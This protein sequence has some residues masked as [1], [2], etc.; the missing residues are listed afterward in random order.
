MKNKFSRY[1]FYFL[2]VIVI[3]AIYLFA[4]IVLVP[5]YTFWKVE[6]WVFQSCPH[7]YYEDFDNVCAKSLIVCITYPLVFLLGLIVYVVGFIYFFGKYSFQL[8]MTT[9]YYFLFRPED[10]DDD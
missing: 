6:K 9:I 5:L 1:F 2:A 8:T 3:F 7:R 4:L 10:S